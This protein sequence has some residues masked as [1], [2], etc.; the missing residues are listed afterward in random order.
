M[1]KFLELIGE[2]TSQDTEL[3][4]KHY[5]ELSERLRKELQGT[6][7]EAFSTV[8]AE[9]MPFVGSDLYANLL[10]QYG[11]WLTRDYS[12]VGAEFGKYTAKELRQRILRDHKDELVADLNQDNLKRI[13]ELESQLAREQE[14]RRY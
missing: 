1:S 14:L 12:R 10:T 7:D 2:K 9:Y 3:L 11:D 5:E 4:E 6:I 13:E 8:I